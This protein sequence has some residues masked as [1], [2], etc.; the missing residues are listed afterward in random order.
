MTF[1]HNQGA[2]GMSDL[3]HNNQVS[4]ISLKDANG[5]GAQNITFTKVITVEIKGYNLLPSDRSYYQVPITP[6][7]QMVNGGTPFGHNL[8]FVTSG[9]GNSPPG[10]S[11]VNPKPPFN[12][13]TILDNIHGR[14]FNSLNDAKVHPKSGAIF[15]TDVM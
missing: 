9:R 12:S 6:D 14:Q 2:L 13:T 11:L 10:L 5:S 4:V 3:E 15:F 8:L 1:H 7:I